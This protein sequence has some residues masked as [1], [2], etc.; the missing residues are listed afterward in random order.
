[1]DPKDIKILVV[2]A[3]ALV[4]VIVVFSVV[5]GNDGP[6]EPTPEPEDPLY[7]ADMIMV[8]DY[9]IS[10]TI[11]TA[12]STSKAPSGKEFVTVL[13]VAKNVSDNSITLNSLYY[14][15]V[16]DD[17]QYKRSLET[18]SHKDH[19]SMDSVS[20]GGSVAN[21]LVFEVPEGA[22]VS[23]CRI[24]WDGFTQ[25]NLYVEPAD[26]KIHYNIG[27]CEIYMTLDAKF[28]VKVPYVISC[29]EISYVSEG[30]VHLAKGPVIY[31][32][33]IWDSDTDGMGLIKPGEVVK[34]TWVFTI[35]GSSFDKIYL[36]NADLDNTLI[37]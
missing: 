7:S 37:V 30:D 14:D 21:I 17:V 34:G 9:S 4:A 2:L 27:D 26:K 12:Y 18:Y 28:C 32:L 10:K 11:P 19:I 25:M 22:D 20:P 3:V 8:C 36:N 6:S 13:F 33:N 5:G 31:D 16:I 23:T 1:M 35:D 29:D 24:V 15:L